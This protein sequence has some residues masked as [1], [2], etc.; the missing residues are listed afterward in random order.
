MYLIICTVCRKI[1]T[2]IETCVS[3]DCDL[4]RDNIWILTG[5]NMAGKGCQIIAI[6]VIYI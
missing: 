2:F 3:N 6:G 5:P 1:S 4:Y